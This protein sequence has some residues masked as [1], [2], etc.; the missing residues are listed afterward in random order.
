[1]HMTRLALL[2]AS[3]A[4]AGHALAQGLPG[5][6]PPIGATPPQTPTEPTPPQQ[7]AKPPALGAPGAPPAPGQ[8]ARPGSKPPALPPAGPAPGGSAS[9]KPAPLP[10]GS[11]TAM[12]RQVSSGTGF[13]IGQ[14][15]LMTNNHVVRDCTEMRARIA[16]GAELPARV[17]A[18]DANR[19]LALLAVEG[20]AGPILRFRSGGELRRGEGVVTYG[21][22][23]A[24]LLSAGPTL[25]TGDVSALTGLRDDPRSYQISAP[26]QPGN[27][28][29]PL[30]DLGGH[31][32]GVVV[33][34]LNAQRIA[35]AT[36]DI[37]QNVN[38]AV[39]GTEALTFL[40][41]QGFRPE[42]AETR[43]TLLS[44]AEVGEIAHLSTVFLRCLR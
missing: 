27:S 4:L 41:E 42:L 30:L 43:G 2:L 11:G 20:D 29:G 35:Q 44:A 39:K 1:M 10:P 12:P 38:F 22:P 36:G 40:R 18:T 19:D 6:P 7:A 25:T 34:K 37:P 23:L 32:V 33:S 8:A 13:V 16:T 24:G 28:G 9:A 5:K 26:V 14:G 17:L 31:I 3:A 15:R 21:F